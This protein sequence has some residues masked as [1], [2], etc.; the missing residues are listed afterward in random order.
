M[1][2]K[3]HI[4]LCLGLLGFVGATC[5]QDAESGR[6]PDWLIAPS[7]SQAEVREVPEEKALVLS[8]GLISRTFRLAPNAATVAFDNLMTGESLLRAVRPEARLR[9]EGR[10]YAVGGLTGQPNHAYLLP[11]WMDH[12]ETEPG[13]FRFVGHVIGETLARFP[14]QRKRYS[15]DRPWPPPGASL[16]LRFEAPGPELQGITVLVHYEMYDSLPLLCKWLTVQNQGDRAVTLETFM[17]EILAAVEGSSAVESIRGMRLP[18]M[19]V[20]TD[21]AFHG[22]TS[23]GANVT[24]NWN[25]DPEYLTQV[26][27]RRLTPCLL[28]VHPPLGPQAL[29]LPGESFQ[30]FRTFELIFDSSDRERKGLAIR[31]MYRTIAPWVTENPLMMHVRFADPESVRRAIDQCS[32]VGFEMVILTFGS[33]FNIENED[34]AYLEELKGLADYAHAKGIELGGYSLLASRRIDD[35]SDVVNPETGKPGGFAAFGN[36]P[37]LGSS[38]GQD[39]FRKLYAFYERTGF[40][41]LEHD[42]AYPGDVCASQVHPG[43]SGLEDSQYTQWKTITD[44]YQWCRS[45][46]IYLNVPDFYYLSGSNKCGMGYRETNWSLPRA[47]QVIHTRQNIFDGTYQKTPSMGWMFVPLTEYQGGG[48]AATIEPLHDHRDHYEMMLAGNLG[49]GVQACFR[50]PR[51]FDTDETKAMVKQWVDFYKRHRLILDSDL[52]HLRR[53]D[54]RDLDY[55]LHVNPHLEEKG[56]LVV[57][58][59]LDHAVRKTLRIPLYYTGVTRTARI[60]EQEGDPRPYRLDRDHTVQI[61]VQV[62]PS[63]VTWFVI[64]DT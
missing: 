40:D 62:P 21:F 55:M 8:N 36:S 49:F 59:P 41:L 39:Y 6:A 10:D 23:A 56:L 14:W 22:M 54:G 35:A 27:Y 43:H 46:G 7:G 31:R 38:W 25:L 29:I 44:F 9:I 24:V 5:R 15:E 45:E 30:T 47:Q 48:E 34:P 42:G 26:N 52:I 4:I 51:L 60:R 64:G 3:L 57:F 12:M 33:G 37:C 16:T 61:E 53:A 63:G 32:E 28:E 19:H 2:A 13:A 1:R 20:E 50:G 17:S 18:D 58:N 11:E